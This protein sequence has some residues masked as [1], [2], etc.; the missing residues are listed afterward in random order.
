LGSPVVG[1]VVRSF[2]H[3]TQV[4]IANEVLAL[5]RL[6]LGISIFSYRKPEGAVA[7]ERFR[8][9]QAPVTYLPDPLNRNVGRVLRANAALVLRHP[10]RYARTVA[11]VLGHTIRN[12]NLDTWRRLLQAA[13]LASLARGAG[14]SRFHAHFADGTTRIA[15]LAGMLTGMPYSFTA[16]A[17]DIFRAGID[18]ELLREKIEGASFV[19][20]VS[21][22]NKRFLDDEVRHLRN[23][24]VRVVYNGVDLDRFRPD[25]AVEREP[26]LI[27]AAGRLV[28]KKGFADLIE[29]CRLLHEH[30]RSF[31]C[32]IIGDGPLRA[33]LEA[34]A[35]DLSGVIEF[36][37]AHSQEELAAEYQ[38][39]AV[40]VLPAVVPPDGNTDALPTV[41]LEAMAS[42]CPVISTRV[43]GIPEIVDNEE[44]GLL[45]APGDVPALAAAI[46]RLLNDPQLRARFGANARR[47]AE[48]R[49]DVTKN[50][51]E[52]YRLFADTARVEPA[53]SR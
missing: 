46:E 17:R 15:M 39:A 7:H 2:P 22:Y 42:G 48:E 52:L 31:R 10:V 26:N 8:Q 6:G 1:Y 16:H 41:L 5:E 37:G 29:A 44:N 11:Y 40:F 45:V 9:I 30:G 19:I 35:A 33:E 36:V 27:F 38:R 43:A 51:A 23:G 18:R 14:V 12:H 47:K 3:P 4:F 32:R 21:E 20:G 13:C 34:Q 53:P 24:H 49:F 28:R 25:P 50:V